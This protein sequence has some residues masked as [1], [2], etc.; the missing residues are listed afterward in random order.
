MPGP[1]ARI[2]TLTTVRKKSAD[3]RIRADYPEA[4][5]DTY[6]RLVLMTIVKCADYRTRFCQTYSTGE[7]DEIIQIET[8]DVGVASRKDG[9]K[10]RSPGDK[11][12]QIYL[13][14]LVIVMKSHKKSKTLPL[15]SVT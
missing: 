12:T 8:E 3:I 5:R 2:V 9:G 1:G 10:N 14:C 15:L 4:P 13:L 11:F 7:T 6:T